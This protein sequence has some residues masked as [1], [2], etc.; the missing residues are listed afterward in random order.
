[1]Y[2]TRK[3]DPE[4]RSMEMMYGLLL[5]APLAVA[6]CTLGFFGYKRVNTRNNKQEKVAPHPFPVK[7]AWAH[8]EQERLRLQH[9]VK[10]VSAQRQLAIGT[11]AD[12][13][14]DDRMLEIEMPNFTGQRRP[15]VGTLFKDLSE[16]AAKEALRALEDQHA[17]GG[18]A[19]KIKGVKKSMRG[20][21]DDDD[22]DDAGRPAKQNVAKNA[23]QKGVGS[24]IRG[25]FLSKIT[26][27]FRKSSQVPSAIE[28]RGIQPSD[29]SD[30][31]SA[32]LAAMDPDSPASSASPARSGRTPTTTSIEVH[33]APKKKEVMA[34]LAPTTP[35]A[36]WKNEWD[37]DEDGPRTAGGRPRRGLLVCCAGGSGHGDGAS[38]AGGPVPASWPASSRALVCPWN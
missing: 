2:A 23:S 32:A 10:Q 33:D 28:V 29:S 22:E 6:A 20:Q 37:E 16:K 25:G 11:H 19:P 34:S 26:S 35:T 17:L 7:K 4:P 5:L 1:M 8:A 38:G 12:G 9:S 14:K 18:D 3:E 15:S 27:K 31:D 30:P 24:S 13:A 21:Q 36:T